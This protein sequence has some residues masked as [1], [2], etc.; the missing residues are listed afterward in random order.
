MK[1]VNP[2]RPENSAKPGLAKK[3][4]PPARIVPFFSWRSVLAL[5]AGLIIGAALGFGY[6]QIEPM[7]ISDKVPVWESNVQIQITNPTTSYIDP[8]TLGNRTEY[9]VAKTQSISFLEYL[10]QI[11]SEEQP[12]Y[13]H[14][15]NE[16][17]EMITLAFN[18]SSASL[19]TNYS[20]TVTTSSTEET[21]FLIVRVPEIFKDYLVAEQIDNQQQQ[22]QETVKSIDTIKAALL[23]AQGELSSIAPG[24]VA[25]SIENNP[26]HVVL[27]AK[28]KALQAQ[29]DILTPQL[30]EII[31]SDNTTTESQDLILTAI[32]K[33]VTALVEAQNELAT[34]EAQLSTNDPSLSLDYK[35][36]RDKVNNLTNQLTILSEERDSLLVSNIDTSTITD[37]LVVGNPSIPA[38]PSILKLNTAI[39]VG[40]LAGLLV[41]WIILNFRWFTQRQSASSEDDE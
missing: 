5:A 15:A 23:E 41:A 11:I 36:A 31:A 18:P 10:S 7:I 8:R 37:Y 24:G 39:L 3:R 22:Y 4:K 35:L 38:P 16:L 27:T 26:T 13:V 20:V 33:T 1:V 21:A 34:L 14:S 40:A 19:T 25:G 32:D 30:A 12:Q 17:S 2:G 29:L 9:Y 6:F 28:I